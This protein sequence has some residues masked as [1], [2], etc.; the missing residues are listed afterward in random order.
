MGLFC[1]ELWV[2]S[3]PCVATQRTVRNNLS[4]LSDTI[5]TSHPSGA[6]AW[7]MGSHGG[8]VSVDPLSCL[9]R[10]RLTCWQMLSCVR[11]LEVERRLTWS[12]SA[13][14]WLFIWNWLCPGVL[15]VCHCV[16]HRMSWV[17]GSFWVELSIDRQRGSLL[18]KQVSLLAV[19]FMRRISSFYAKR[20]IAPIRLWTT[21]ERKEAQSRV[22]GLFFQSKPVL[23]Q[24][25]LAVDL[26]I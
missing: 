26:K 14:W 24:F 5:G 7:Q 22:D 8:C 11:C 3:D 16:K 17:T 4:G 21:N 23:Q 10:V 19:G 20:E 6:S 25:D 9:M 2:S 12:L 13:I 1:V 18:A 15:L